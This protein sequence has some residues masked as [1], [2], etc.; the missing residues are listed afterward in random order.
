M[1][2]ENCLKLADFWGLATNNVP[3]LWCYMSARKKGVLKE[4][5]YTFISCLR[6]R[7]AIKMKGE[8]RGGV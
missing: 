1:I 3:A 8:Q 6:Q 2:I 5:H 4:K 7:N